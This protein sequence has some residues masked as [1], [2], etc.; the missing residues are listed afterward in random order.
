MYLH[1]RQYTEN[2]DPILDM[3]SKLR[4]LID[5]CKHHIPKGYRDLTSAKLPDLSVAERISTPR[6]SDGDGALLQPDTDAQVFELYNRRR[7]QLPSPPSWM[8][9]LP[10]SDL[11]DAFQ[12]LPDD[13]PL[14]GVKRPTKILVLVQWKVNLGKLAKIFAS[15]GL[16]VQCLDGRFSGPERTRI[17]AE[18]MSDDAHPDYIP[19]TTDFL[20]NE[21]RPPHVPH[22]SMILIVTSVGQTGLNLTRAAV[23]IFY[24]SFSLPQRVHA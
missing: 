1:F 20:P 17:I 6:L 8:P 4:R 2:S 5:L 16:H 23:A 10:L 19:R 3:G 9:N 12:P 11:P 24:V 15:E 22:Y 13:T 18:F 21:R 7:A 14:V